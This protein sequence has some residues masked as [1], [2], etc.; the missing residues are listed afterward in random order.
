MKNN[1]KQLPIINIAGSKFTLI[2]LLV[3]IAIIAILAGMLLPALG[4]ARDRARSANCISNLKQCATAGIMYSNDNN[5]LMVLIGE[6]FY[7]PVIGASSSYWAA[8]LTRSG[9][10]GVNEPA[11][12]CPTTKPVN[13]PFTSALKFTYSTCIIERSVTGWTNRSPYAPQVF[14]AGPV[15]ASQDCDAN[16][17]CQEQYIAVNKVQSASTVYYNTDSGNTEKDNDKYKWTTAGLAYNIWGWTQTIVAR[18]SDRVNMNFVD[19]HAGAYKGEEIA[20]LMKDNPDYYD[21]SV[22][23]CDSKGLRECK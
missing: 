7:S 12:Y 6:Y 14:V 19:G 17:T 16:K 10:L 8:V 5:D 11:T 3:V 2:E 22:Y 21:S 4:K 9:Y 18:H 1:F 15:T 20:A 13:D 23:I